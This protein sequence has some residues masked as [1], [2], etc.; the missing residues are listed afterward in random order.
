MIFSNFQLIIDK[1]ISQ[2]HFLLYK[3]EKKKKK[4]NKNKSKYEEILK[5]LSKLK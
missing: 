3:K 5:G 1:L 4:E 2:K